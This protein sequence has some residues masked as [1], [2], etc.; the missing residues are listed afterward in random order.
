MVI[1]GWSTITT[2]ARLGKRAAEVATLRL[3]D[4]HWRVGELVVVAELEQADYVRRKVDRRP[5]NTQ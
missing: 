4:V 5:Q 3:D 1:V 2:L